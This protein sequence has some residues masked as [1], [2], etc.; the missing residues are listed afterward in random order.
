[1]NRFSQICKKLHIFV[2]QSYKYVCAKLEKMCLVGQ[3][4][5]RTHIE[6]LELEQGPVPANIFW[7]KNT[8]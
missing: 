6:I 7:G 8:L 3:A 1:M 4:P 2:R 5:C